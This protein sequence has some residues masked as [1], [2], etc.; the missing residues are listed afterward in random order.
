MDKTKEANKIRTKLLLQVSN[1]VL[2][3][4]KST[5]LINSTSA[6]K[7]YDNYSNIEIT[8]ENPY[9]F[10]ILERKEKQVLNE[11]T[12]FELEKKNEYDYMEVFRKINKIIIS[13]KKNKNFYDKLDS[14]EMKK[15]SEDTA[16]T[17]LS[18]NVEKSHKIILFEEDNNDLLNK[19]IKFLR[20][21]AKSF[22][23]RFRKPK[24]KAKSFYQNTQFKSFANLKRPHK[25]NESTVSM[26][27][28]NKKVFF[29]ETI[30]ENSEIFS[31]GINRGISFYKNESNK[32]TRNL[33]KNKKSKIS[34]NLS[35][36][37]HEKENLNKIFYKNDIDNINPFISSK[38]VIKIKPEDKL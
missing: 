24:K 25:K 31:S 27:F 14:N 23:M 9:E 26:N 34:F 33:T 21:K 29:D 5:M 1:E 36:Y 16:D 11:S 32:S 7:L 19:S 37:E 38:T 13:D 35:T 22:I 10:S 8:I 2:N 18:G 20:T 6:K 28:K 17:T 12:L 30:T 4:K 15:L 3:F